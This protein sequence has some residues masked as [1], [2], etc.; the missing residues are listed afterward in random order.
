MKEFKQVDWLISLSL[1]V[2]FLVAGL[3]DSIW[4][5][6]GYFSVGGWQII[7]M[8]VHELSGWFVPKGSLRRNYHLVVLAIVIVGP[9]FLVF[10]PLVYVSGFILFTLLFAAPVMALF[11]TSLCYD[12]WK[13]LSKRPISVIK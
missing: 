1:I 10:P 3:L 13:K 6:Y 5:I 4:F 2:L 8:L 11:Y 7:S 9:S 12:E